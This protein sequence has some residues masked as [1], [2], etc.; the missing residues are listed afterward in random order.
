MPEPYLSDLSQGGASIRKP[1]SFCHICQNLID[2]PSR[3]PGVIMTRKHLGNLAYSE[4][5]PAA[6]LSHVRLYVLL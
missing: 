3:A 4:R 6:F 5:S 2:H 1:T